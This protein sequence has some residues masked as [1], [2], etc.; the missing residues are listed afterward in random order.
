MT[1]HTS[2]RRRTGD[3]SLALAHDQTLLVERLQDSDVLRLVG[4]DGQVC[5]AVHLTAAGPVLRFEG[6][7]MLEASGNLAL[8]AGRIALHGRDGIALSTDGD[9]HIHAAGDLHSSARAQIIT[10]QLGNVNIKANDDV[11]LNGERVKMNCD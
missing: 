4:R 2:E 11:K 3:L 10:A 5:L 1:E 8:S 6:N 9:A 7:L